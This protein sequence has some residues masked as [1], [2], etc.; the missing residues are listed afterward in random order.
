MP[1]LKWLPAVLFLC[2]LTTTCGINYDSG[3]YP[4]NVYFPKEGGCKIIFGHAD[5]SGFTIY[6]GDES[7]SYQD[8][9]ST[10]YEEDPDHRLIITSSDW[11]TVKHWLDSDSIVLYVK[12]NTTGK[13]RKAWIDVHQPFYDWSE[14]NIK[15]DK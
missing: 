8:V 4:S 13:K 11:I 6:E 7:W 12:P 5:V 1:R 15:Q 3:E 9:D 2:L 10:Y 14:I